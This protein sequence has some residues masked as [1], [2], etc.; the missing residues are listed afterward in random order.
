MLPTA[1]L[2]YVTLS[3]FLLMLSLPLDNEAKTKAKKLDE[4][5]SGQ[6]TKDVKR[7]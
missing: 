7:Y 6:K 3:T 5:M 2:C 4:L 1:F